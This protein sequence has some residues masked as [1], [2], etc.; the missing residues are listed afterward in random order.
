MRTLVAVALITALFFSGCAKLS[1]SNPEPFPDLSKSEQEN[2]RIAKEFALQSSTYVFDGSNLKLEKTETLKC[3]YC[4]SFTFS[5]ASSHGGHGNRTGA[6]LPQVAQKHTLVI[7]TREGNVTSAVVD[8]VYDELK[9]QYL[10][11]GSSTTPEMT[12]ELCESARGNWNECGSACRGAPE[13]T[14]CT[15]QCVPMCE[16][17]GFAGFGCPDGFECADYLPDEQTPDAMGI[18]KPVQN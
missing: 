2:W 11:G 15:M 10:P 13:G 6:I 5:Y 4:W 17:G 14:A 3:P 18:C 8:G 12:K 9:G 16:C 1:N 7:I